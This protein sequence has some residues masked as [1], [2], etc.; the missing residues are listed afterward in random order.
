M[1][2]QVLRHRR[3]NCAA[4]T[5]RKRDFRFQKKKFVTT[6]SS[7]AMGSSFFCHKQQPMRIVRRL[8]SLQRGQRQTIQQ[9]KRV[10][11]LVIVLRRFSFFFKKYF[12]IAEWRIWD[13]GGASS[14]FHFIGTLKKKIIKKNVLFK[15]T[16]KKSSAAFHFSLWITFRLKCDRSYRFYVIDGSS[17]VA[18]GHK[19]F[20]RIIDRLLLHR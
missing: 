8:V 6:G 4:R 20:I 19:P 7:R 9:G 14:F 2:D 18:S 11:E 10:E 13:G 5:N 1:L 17:W 15:L 16:K 3:R 12:Y